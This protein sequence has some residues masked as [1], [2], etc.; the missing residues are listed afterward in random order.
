[1]LDLIAQ[2]N[3]AVNGVVW[4][5]PMLILIIG[6]GIYMTLRTKVFQITYAKHVTAETIGGVFKKGSHVKN[7][8]RMVSVHQINITH[9]HADMLRL[10]SDRICRRKYLPAR[11]LPHIRSVLSSLFIDD[12]DRASPGLTAGDKGIYCTHINKMKGICFYHEFTVF[13]FRKCQNTVVAQK[14]CK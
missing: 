3:S 13:E 11:A 12:G 8:A 1:M 7:H 4:G 9:A 2:I 5:I 6:T 10:G 14:N